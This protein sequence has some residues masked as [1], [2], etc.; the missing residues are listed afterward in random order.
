[1]LCSGQQSIR[2]PPSLLGRSVSAHFHQRKSLSAFPSLLLLL[3]L[4]PLCFCLKFRALNKAGRHPQAARGLL[5]KGCQS[6]HQQII[7]L[8][9]RPCK[10]F[11]PPKDTQAG[12][13]KP[14]TRVTH[15]RDRQ[16]W[17]AALKYSL[18]RVYFL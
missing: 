1:M 5:S 14:A 6:S 11:T 15:E 10:P 12:R 13:I 3:S 2:N 18:R 8:G 17:E 7:S 4:V 16:F 9:G